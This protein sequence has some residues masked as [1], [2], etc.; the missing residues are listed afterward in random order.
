MPREEIHQISITYTL[1]LSFRKERAYDYW[2]YSVLQGDRELRG[3]IATQLLGDARKFHPKALINNIT[4]GGYEDAVESRIHID[5]S[6]FMRRTYLKGHSIQLSFQVSNALVAADNGLINV[7][8]PMRGIKLE[9]KTKIAASA[10]YGY[11]MCPGYAEEEV[12][13]NLCEVFNFQAFDR[14]FQT[15]SWKRKGD[16]FH[17]FVREECGIWG[18]IYKQM[19]I[20]WK[21]ES[22]KSSVMDRVAWSTVSFRDSTSVYRERSI[23]SRGDCLIMS[24][25]GILAALGSEDGRRRRTLM[26]IITLIAVL[27]VAHIPGS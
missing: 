23:F 17:R 2:W 7:T 9:A 5:S 13:A 18:V 3:Q 26:L 6:N 11:L 8:I 12:E 16:E 22:I 21:D 1:T 4:I 10:Y 24:L 14:P 19:T 15:G 27:A 25:T 20:S